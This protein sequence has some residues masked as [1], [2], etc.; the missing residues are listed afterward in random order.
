MD[1]VAL[2]PSCSDMAPPSWP[3]ARVSGGEAASPSGGAGNRDGFVLWLFPVGFS[4]GP[5]FGRPGD[6]EP[7]ALSPVKVAILAGWRPLLRTA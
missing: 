5:T 6:R 3:L 2:L 1:L 4:G 7:V